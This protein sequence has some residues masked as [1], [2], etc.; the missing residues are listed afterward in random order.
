MAPGHRIGGKLLAERGIF[1]SHPV[2]DHDRA[3]ID[4][5]EL[6]DHRAPVVD[7]IL[8]VGDFSELEIVLRDRFP[9]RLE[10][11]LTVADLL[12][13]DVDLAVLRLPDAGLSPSCVSHI[14]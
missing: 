2:I 12:G 7:R 9:G 14:G 10:D 4:F 13:D 3:G 8:D 11:G 1:G 6:L 5:L